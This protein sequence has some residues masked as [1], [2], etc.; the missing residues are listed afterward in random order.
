MTIF[1]I[2]RFIGEN[3]V[4]RIKHVCL[5]AQNAAIR[6]ISLLPVAS[7]QQNTDLFQPIY[8]ST[9]EID[10]SVANESGWFYINAWDARGERIRSGAT[11]LGCLGNLS[12]ALE[13]LGQLNAA[14][15]S[16]A[17]GALSLLPTAGAL[18]GA[19]AKEKWIFYNLVPVAGVLSMFLSLGRTVTHSKAGD[20]DPKSG[21]SYGG[22]MPSTKS[23]TALDTIDNK[24][25]NRS[26]AEKFAATVRDRVMDDVGGSRYRKV[27]LGVVAQLCLVGVILTAM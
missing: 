4:R 6:S 3:I 9:G 1:V 22:I 25:S 26:G 12:W 18:I 5:S 10:A 2:I 11:T 19:P 14:E 20:Y 23:Q 27:W 16:G 7:A 8:T 21:F 13:N 15:Y 24:N 17:A